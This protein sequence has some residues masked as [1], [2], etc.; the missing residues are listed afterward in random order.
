MRPSLSS[1]GMTFLLWSTLCRL[2]LSLNLSQS[3]DASGL[4]LDALVTRWRGGHSCPKYQE[5]MIYIIIAIW[6]VTPAEALYTELEGN[7]DKWV[8]E[9]VTFQR[10]HGARPGPWNLRALARPATSIAESPR[11]VSVPVNPA[12]AV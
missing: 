9:A 1:F 3:L 11:I 7:G 12:I 2:M 5:S 8:E 10:G 6:R 4:Y